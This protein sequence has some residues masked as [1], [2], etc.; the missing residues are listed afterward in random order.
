MTDRVQTYNGVKQFGRAAGNE[1]T[2]MFHNK[3][4]GTQIPATW[5]SCSP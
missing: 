5:P 4:V 1:G 3:L 2:H